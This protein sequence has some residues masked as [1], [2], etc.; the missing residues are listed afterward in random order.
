MIPETAVDIA[1]AVRSGAVTAS[2]VLAGCRERVEALDDTLHAFC[3]TAFDQARARA[4]EIDADVRAG[5]P[6]GPLAGVPVAVKDL[7]PTRDLRTTSGSLAYRDLVPEVDDVCV[8]RL[9]A[10]GALI[11]GKTNASEFGYG[12][13]G[14]NP[15]FPPTLNPWD[16]R[17]TPGGS[18]AGSAV[19]V[20]TG[21][22]PV[23]LGS[24]GGGSIRVPA[25][26]CGVYG[27]K[28]AMGRVPLW[29]GCRDERSPGMSSWESL[30]HIGP[31]TRTVA[32][33]ALILS[34]IAGPDPR[35]RHSIPCDDV[36]WHDLTLPAGLRVGYSPDLGHARVDPD[37][38]AV[39]ERAI[40]ALDV[41][42][43]RL[44]LDWPDLRET[45]DA[46]VAA[47]TDLVGLRELAARV[48][49]SA[50]VRAVLERSWTAEQFTDA[51]RERKAAANRMARL[52]DEI[53]I[54]LTPTVSTTAYDRALPGPAT[55][56][57]L[58]AAPDEWTPFSA[59][60]NLTG[61]PAASAPVGL[62]PSGLPVGLQIMGPHLGD[63]QVLAVSRLIEQTTWITSGPRRVA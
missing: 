31:L 7:I 61:R 53:D 23:A 47:E 32:D 28:P 8:A 36:D 6:G 55:L 58:P 43:R 30:E 16:T 17:L 41:P 56:A 54:L 20:A 18:S 24:D 5:R 21:M 2:E 25:A 44:D 11:V 42:V 27:I 12:P 9:R 19:A 15:V 33:A 38:R 50:P 51:V 26:L 52:T 46:L 10:A 3:T 29:P 40:A 4:A 1:R 49:L 22:V 14:E 39:V 63:H 34:V 62:T 60:A 57:G 13:R 59:I 37:V 45:F 35:D 48:P